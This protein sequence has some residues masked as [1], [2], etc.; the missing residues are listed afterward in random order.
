MPVFK[1][2]WFSVHASCPDGHASLGLSHFHALQEADPR[3]LQGNECGEGLIQ[4]LCFTVG[5]RSGAIITKPAP[6]AEHDYAEA[7]SRI[8]AG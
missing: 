2:V 1:A 3:L 6:S 7:E 5:E 4:R 8:T